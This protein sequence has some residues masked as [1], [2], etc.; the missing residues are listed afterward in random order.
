[1]ENGEEVAVT[2]PWDNTSLYAVGEEEGCIEL[3]V[4]YALPPAVPGS[5][6]AG[7]TA[8]WG[9]GISDAAMDAA[10][11]ALEAHI[12]EMQDVGYKGKRLSRRVLDSCLTMVIIG[13][14][15]SWGRYKTETGLRRGARC[16]LDG[17][18]HDEAVRQFG[19]TFPSADCSDSN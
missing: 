2:I 1:L 7:M 17:E 14:E 16:P 11:R 15:I 13:C 12:K 4:L 19:A 8:A 3:Y 6:P 10:E 9:R 5:K 18:Y